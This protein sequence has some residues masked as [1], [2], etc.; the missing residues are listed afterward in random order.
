M[1]QY[2]YK[3]VGVN[4]DTLQGVYRAKSKGEV[5]QM[6]RGN[7]SYPVSI[8]EEFLG[9]NREIKLFS[10]I[11]TKDLAVFCR[12]MYAM[13]N[14][15]VPIVTCLEIL[16][17]QTEHKKFKVVISEVY[18][19][20]NKGSTLSEAL[21][22]YPDY[23]SDLMTHM[24]SAGEASGNLDLILQRLAVHYEK[25][26]KIKNKI[27]GA[28]VYPVILTFVSMVVV[29]FLLTFV[30]PQFIA[31]FEDSGVALPLPTRILLFMSF[32]VVHYWYLL[33]I[34]IFGLVY[35]LSRYFMTPAGHWN[36]DNMMLKMP[37]VKT[38]VMKVITARF[39]RTLSTMVTSGIPLIQALENV[40]NVVGNR[41][42]ISGLRKVREEVQRGMDLAT[43][44]R[45]YSLFPPMVGNMIHIGEESGTLDDMLDKTANFYDDEVDTAMQ[46]MVAMFEPLL[47]VVMAVM[48]GF[49]VISIAMPLFKMFEAI[50]G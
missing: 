29:T 9:E 11:K 41:V 14:A 27:R 31:L 7:Q 20:V 30:L 50:K 21:K 46:Q 39:T 24:I 2:K 49:I 34:G 4:G 28:M 25:E 37:Y 10:G 43:P 3:A 35:G 23:F 36:F 45:R 32:V 6:L 42:V 12:Q 18:E 33:L 17:S 44:I 40:E 19:E 47:I 1:P 13:I 22:Q 15:G 8:S 26:T 38:V 48:V 16:K 5:I